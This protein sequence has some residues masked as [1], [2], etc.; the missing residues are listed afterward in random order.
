LCGFKLLILLVD[1]F[2]D[3]VNVIPSNRTVLKQRK[4][5]IDASFITVVIYKKAV[6][7]LTGFKTFL[8]LFN[9]CDG[10]RTCLIVFRIAAG[11][12]AGVVTEGD[13]VYQHHSSARVIAGGVALTSI[14]VDR[15]FLRVEKKTLPLH[16]GYCWSPPT[17]PLCACMTSSPGP[18]KNRPLPWRA[19]KTHRG[20]V[21]GRLL[22]VTA[23]PHS[24]GGVTD[25]TEEDGRG[26]GR[27]ASSL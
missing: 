24:L 22:F 4:N 12:V 1:S 9:S 3:V 8:L 2:P 11:V 6:L 17:C 19:E 13:E 20:G 16:G 7:A 26:R 15:F 10:F 14:R 25:S 27:W 23:E 21:L 5:Y 18:K